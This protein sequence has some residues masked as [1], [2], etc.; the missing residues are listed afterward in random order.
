MKYCPSQANNEF[1]LAHG[2]S[3]LPTQNC[4]GPRGKWSPLPVMKVNR[5]LSP[6]LITFT[7]KMQ[8][9][10]SVFTRSLHRGQQFQQ[11]TFCISKFQPYRSRPLLYNGST[12]MNKPLKGRRKEFNRQGLGLSQPNI[13][14]T[15]RYCNLPFLYSILNI[16]QKKFISRQIQLFAV[17]E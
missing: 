7:S 10:L 8:E 17:N 6:L 15:Q 5:S 3:Q 13:A 4:K 9:I 11:S 16:S 2:H 12:K 14:D 1:L